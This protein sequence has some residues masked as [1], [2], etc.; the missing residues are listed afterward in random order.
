MRSALCLQVQGRYHGFKDEATPL[1]LQQLS[2]I[3]NEQTVLVEHRFEVVSQEMTEPFRGHNIDVGLLNLRKRE[4]QFSQPGGEVSLFRSDLFLENTNS[5][6]HRAPNFSTKTSCWH[7]KADTRV[8]LRQM[9]DGEHLSDECLPPACGNGKYHS[10]DFRR[11]RRWFSGEQIS[12]RLPECQH[13]RASNR[14]SLAYGDR[15]VWR[16]DRRVPG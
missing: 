14:E 13:G 5:C 7:D 2:L 6:A 12:L 10:L 11:A 8:R 3:E 9:R 4:A 15:Y 1:L 16:Q